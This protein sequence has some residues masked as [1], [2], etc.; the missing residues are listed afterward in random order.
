MILFGSG[1]LGQERQ[2]GDVPTVARC[3]KHVEY[4]KNL[5]QRL[6]DRS[7]LVCMVDLSGDTEAFNGKPCIF[8]SVH[9]IAK[10]T[11]DTA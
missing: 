11:Q 10:C 9:E 1:R 3:V 7:D 6:L 4:T 8:S 2:Y 5:N